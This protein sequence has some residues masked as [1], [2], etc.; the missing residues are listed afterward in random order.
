M[1]YTVAGAVNLDQPK[2]LF[3]SILPNNNGITGNLGQ[4]GFPVLNC[5]T[6]TTF[7]SYKTGGDT[8]YVIFTFPVDQTADCFCVAGHNLNLAGSVLQFFTSPDLVTGFTNFFSS[9]AIQDGD[10]IIVLTAPLVFRRLS[11]QFVS[12][13]AALPFISI[14]KAGMAVSMPT[15]IAPPYVP[16]NR[17]RRVEL[18]NSVSM[19]NNF[20]GNSSYPKG[21]ETDVSFNNLAK[22]FIDGT[23]AEFAK[24]YDNG[25]TFFFAGSP[26]LM[27]L[28][29]G[30]CWRRDGAGELRPENIGGDWA[31]LKMGLAIDG[32]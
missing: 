17:A 4:P 19:G 3:K 7:D 15:T 28:D 26:A 16:I 13:T 25:G 11:I 5:L 10:A 24:H 6:D 12:P 22:S 2:M 30:Y 21:R 18:L 31:N 1:I 23:L 14:F 29:V 27:P 32:A 8:Q 9:P 20:L